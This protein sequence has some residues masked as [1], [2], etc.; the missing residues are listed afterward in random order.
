MISSVS[1]VGYGRCSCEIFFNS[2]DLVISVLKLVITCERV[3]G[4]GSEEKKSISTKQGNLALFVT[5]LVTR[6]DPIFLESLRKAEGF[7]QSLS[8]PTLETSR[9][10]SPLHGSRYP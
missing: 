2:A 3:R 6:S 5:W 4:P 8:S 10:V 1:A 9:V 7:S